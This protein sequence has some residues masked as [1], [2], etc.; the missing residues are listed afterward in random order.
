MELILQG[1]QAV[2]IAGAGAKLGDVEAWSVGHVDHEGV[3]EN[4]QVVL[5]RRGTHVQGAGTRWEAFEQFW[6]ELPEDT[7]EEKFKTNFQVYISSPDCLTTTETMGENHFVGIL[8][9]WSVW[10][11]FISYGFSPKSFVVVEQ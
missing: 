11:F 1:V 3:G 7:A 2:A 5:L 4:H 6:T 9:I 10:S 8:E